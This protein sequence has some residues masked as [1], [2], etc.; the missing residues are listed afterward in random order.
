MS[1][2]QGEGPWNLQSTASQLEAQVITWT[3]NWHLKLRGGE[4]RETGSSTVLKSPQPV[5]SDAITG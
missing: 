4:G 2:G 3:C 1:E 5:E